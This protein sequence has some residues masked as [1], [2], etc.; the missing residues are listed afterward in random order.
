MG[1]ERSAVDL[2][3]PTATGD[4]G[5][6]PFAHLLVYCLDREMTGTLVLQ[7]ESARHALYVER[8]VPAKARSG[9]T[10]A[11][12]GQIL[13][14][15]DAVDESMVR[16]ALEVAR[17]QRVPLGEALIG[18]GVLDRPTLRD[19]LRVQLRRRVVQFARLPAHTAFAF[20]EHF[21]LLSGW[22]GPE[23]TPVEPLALVLGS[24]RALPDRERW[25]AVL[26][27][28]QGRS[29]GLHPSTDASRFFPTDRDRLVVDALRAG[30]AT[31]AGLEASRLASRDDLYAFLY[32]L[33]ITRHLTA[34]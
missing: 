29:L 25:A 13:V 9:E 10:G 8:G 15:I 22:G 32:A 34:E 28:L 31:I 17:R 27:P 18:E 16:H 33:A 21:N 3:N 1:D 24:V 11:L 20:Y 12:I 30:G 5:R 7:A 26:G 2:S 23:T 19:A 6:T 14:D 4:L